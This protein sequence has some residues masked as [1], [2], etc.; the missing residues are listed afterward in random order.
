MIE[1][2]YIWFA[3]GVESM[4]HFLGIGPRCVRSCKLRPTLQYVKM[5]DNHPR[6]DRSSTADVEKQAT[7]GSRCVRA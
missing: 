3:A 1:A 2:C 7:A 4:L 5:G 6:L